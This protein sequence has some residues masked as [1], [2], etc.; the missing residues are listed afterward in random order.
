MF[1]IRVK[2]YTVL[3]SILQKAFD[4]VVRDNLWHKMI[5]L[6]IRGKM[7]NIN[8]SMYAVVKTRVKYD[9][10]LGNK[11]FCSLGVRQGECLSPLLF[12]LFLNDL[13]EMFVSEG[14]DG[15]DIDMF[16]KFALLYPGDI[17]LF[18]KTC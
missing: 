4:Y 12:S 14:Y 7:L 3:S 6:G 5:K 13:E 15:L 11:F 9:N 17:V 2:S 1:L 8:K 16:K 18:C 10:K